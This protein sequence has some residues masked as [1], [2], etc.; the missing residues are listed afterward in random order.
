MG[1]CRVDPL[2]QGRD[3]AARGLE[4]GLEPQCLERGVGGGANDDHR[5]VAC[6]VQE[7]QALV[8]V[9]VGDVGD[10][11]HHWARLRS[12][13]QPVGAVD[14]RQ[15]AVT[16][17]LGVASGCDGAARGDRC[18][19]RRPRPGQPPRGARRPEPR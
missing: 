13:A 4:G 8:A 2:G 19:R 5:E 7:D 11:V 14:V 10:R 17:D 16:V 3:G 6:V 15:P 18:A 9:E 1:A 12:R